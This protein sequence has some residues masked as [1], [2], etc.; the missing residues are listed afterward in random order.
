MFTRFDN[1][2]GL[3][4]IYFILYDECSSKFS[5]FIVKAV[6]MCGYFEKCFQKKEKNLFEI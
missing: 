1:L 4:W 3:V 2:F 6:K 5:D